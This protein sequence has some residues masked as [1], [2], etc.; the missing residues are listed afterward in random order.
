MGEEK[1]GKS[2]AIRKGRERARDVDAD[3][4]LN[5]ESVAT[6]SRRASPATDAVGDVKTSYKRGGPRPWEVARAA[7][8]AK[9]ATVKK[10]DQDPDAADAGSAFGRAGLPPHM[11]EA[12]RTAGLKRTTEIQRLAIPELTSG[13]DVV[14]LA[15]TGS[16]K[17]FAYTLPM[18]ASVGA[19]GRGGTK[20]QGRCCPSMIVLVPNVELGRQVAY[21]AELA[22][23]WTDTKEY[24]RPAVF[25]LLGK[26]KKLLKPTAPKARG[27]AKTAAIKRK[28]QEKAAIRTARAAAREAA[29]AAARGEG[30]NDEEAAAAGEEAADLA[31][32]RAAGE[33]RLGA[34]EGF[35]VKA[36]KKGS[37]LSG[38]MEVI[39]EFR[40]AEILIATPARLLSMMKD[41]WV[42]PGRIKHVVVDEADEMLSR[43]FEKEVA[44]VLDACYQED[45]MNK[46]GGKVQFCFAAA[47]MAEEGPILGAFRR[48]AENLRWVSTAHFGGLH[49]QLK[50]RVRNVTG[51]EGRRTELLRALTEDKKH[52]A[53]VFCSSPAE[54]DECAEHVNK[55][56]FTAMS[57]HGKTADRG[58][59]MDEF[60]NGDLPVLVCTDLAARGIDFPDLHHVVHY[61]P[62]PDKAIHLHRCGRTARVGQEGPFLVTCLVDR[63]EELDDEVAAILG[64]GR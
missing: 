1:S 20:V 19:P 45:G 44:A 21:M 63:D 3:V 30:A 64:T 41:G 31:G 23:E 39:P 47:T 28:V 34:K 14:I 56:G 48:G 35:S 33:A 4:G 10:P 52:Q 55:N 25:S 60:F 46:F 7:R 5:D 36:G 37:K 42:L 26:D 61:T 58:V 13:E 53:L 22:A 8:E 49:P 15:E 29:E 32:S 43:G 12:M 59:A 54:A 57:F 9:A 27:A 6:M 16:G 38:D 11:V 24:P 17:T 2:E 18:V 51:E 40:R 62:A 50:Q